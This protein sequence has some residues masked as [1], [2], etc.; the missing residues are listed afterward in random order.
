MPSLRRSASSCAEI[1]R[2][3]RQHIGVGDGGR[4][5]L[6]LADLG[7][8]LAARARSPR[9]A[10]PRPGSA[11]A[12]RSCASL[13]KLCRKQTATASI[14]CA[15]QLG[16]D[17]GA[18]PARRAPAARRR[19]RRRARARRSAGRAAP[20][21]RAAPCRCRTA[22]SGAPRRSRA[23]RGSPPSSPARCARPCARSGRWWR[24]SCRARPARPRTAGTWPRASME[25][26]PSITP[27]SGASVVVSTLMA[28]ALSSISRTTSV[29]VPPI[30]TARRALHVSCRRS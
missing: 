16:R 20:A 2:H 1:A 18:P 15:A 10:A 6:V 17:A 14:L 4:G 12:R 8:D 22:R 30:S 27:R 11:P 13:V 21:D 7:T 25:R 24:A 3:A 9:P 23:N 5:A 28:W 29:N 26:T 19:R